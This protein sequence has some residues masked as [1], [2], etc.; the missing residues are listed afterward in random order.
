MKSASLPRYAMALLNAAKPAGKLEKVYGDLD[1]I[2]KFAVSDPSFRLFLETPGIK[3]D[4]KQ[5]VVD[6]ICK[7]TK[8]DDLTRN[9][10]SLL[11]EN[12]RLA[13]LAKIV[14]TFEEYYRKEL[15]QV[16]CTVTSSADLSIVQ[17]KQVEEASTQECWYPI[18]YTKCALCSRRRRNLCSYYDNLWRENMSSYVR[19]WDFAALYHSPKIYDRASRR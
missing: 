12:R 3:R 5:N 7:A 16:M 10:L 14:D 13:D 15:G 9:F 6:D 4:Q 1:A 2:R 11:L 19:R 17:R 18:C 8:A